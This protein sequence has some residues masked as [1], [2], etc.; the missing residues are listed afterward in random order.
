MFG[1]R[2]R[3]GDQLGRSSAV[4]LMLLKARKTGELIADFDYSIPVDWN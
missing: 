2:P 3:N 4:G 1:V